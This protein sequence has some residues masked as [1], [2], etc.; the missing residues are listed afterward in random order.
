[1]EKDFGGMASMHFQWL[2]A[3]R[4]FENSNKAFPQFSH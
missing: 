1:M 2:G 3:L 4:G